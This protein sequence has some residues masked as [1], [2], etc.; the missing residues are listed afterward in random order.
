MT[1]RATQVLEEA[2]DLS[3]E[4]RAE[5]AAQLLSS[6]DGPADADAE[7]AWLVEIQRRAT[8]A[9]SG[10]SAGIPRDEARARVTRRLSGL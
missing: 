6:L 1:A 10:E 4:D 2:L 5:L 8:R 7:A 9:A 3:A